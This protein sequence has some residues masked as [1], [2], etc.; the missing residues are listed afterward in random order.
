M[1]LLPTDGNLI[2]PS[3]IDFAV[4]LGAIKGYTGFRKF[5]VNSAVSGTED[6]WGQGG[7]MVWPDTATVVSVVSSSAEDDPAGAGTS[8]GAHEVTIQ[9]LDAD[10]NSVQE[11]VTMSGTTP[12]VTTQTF[13]RANRMFIGE[14]G[15][16]D[17]NVG[18]IT[19]SIGGNVQE[20]IRAS[21]GQSSVLLYTV[22]AGYIFML[23]YYGV[24]VGRMGGSADAN[25]RGQIRLYDNTVADA[26]EH[27][28]WRTIS[29]LYLYNGQEHVNKRTVTILPEK[30]DL[31]VQVT[32]STGTTQAHAIV[33][34]FLIEQATQGSF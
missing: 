7:V 22:P 30:T 25:I 19:A 13:L 27:Q 9:G 17:T 28:G 18:N 11:T 24:G 21:E 23:N 31:R 6:V 32:L 5:G 3:D 4:G 10:Y 12:V 15:S 8:T 33:G 2:S 29:N 14:C 34:G 1:A 26:S 16:A 20:S